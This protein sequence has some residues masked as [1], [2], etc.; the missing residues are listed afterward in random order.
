M[1]NF[2]AYHN[3]D[4]RG[5]FG[6]TDFY[7][8]FRTNVGDILY[9]VLGK[10]NKSTKKSDYF[11]SGKYLIK[12]VRPNDSTGALSK[13]NWHLEIEASKKLECPGLFS[14]QAGFDAEKYR[15]YIIST[16]GFKPQSDNTSEFFELFDRII[17][18]VEAVVADEFF[19]VEPGE[20]K[21]ENSP[22]NKVMRSILERRGQPKFRRDLL[23]VYN[24]RCCITGC[25][26]MELL[27]AAHINPF[28]EDGDNSLSNG[29]ILRADIHTLFDRNLLTVDEKCIVRIS[30]ELIGSEY[31]SLKGE[32]IQRNPAALPSE[33]SLRKRYESFMEQENSLR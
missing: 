13:K 12:S 31:E 26:V 20:D 3:L 22:L 28:S 30:K 18:G 19:G 7:T 27:E 32:K 5:P 25:A 17:E 11:L 6:G 29:F 15:R 4:K 9:V 8:D 2:H 10:E 33:F 14:N 21:D 16:G 24:N 23:K 1:S